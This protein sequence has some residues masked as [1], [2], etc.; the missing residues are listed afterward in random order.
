MGERIPLTSSLSSEL[1]NELSL[2]LHA[3]QLTNATAPMPIL[4]CDK[5]LYI[6]SRIRVRKPLKR[7]TW[8]SSGKLL[9]A[10]KNVLFR[11]TVTH[12]II[13]ISHEIDVFRVL[14]RLALNQLFL[15][16][17]RLS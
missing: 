16:L 13:G 14:I 9:R 15:F 4:Q 1:D 5:T 17:C 11:V 7:A 2:V 8:R 12:K 6:H 10:E 3:S